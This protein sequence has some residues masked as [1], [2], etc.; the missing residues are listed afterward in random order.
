MEFSKTE[1][2]TSEGYFTYLKEFKG[3]HSLNAVVGYSYFEKNGENFNAENYDFGVEGLKYWDLESGSYLTD[4][5]A[6]MGS[7]KILR[8]VCSL[9]MPVP[10]IHIMINIW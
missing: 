3:G 7:K 5:K 9:F 10:I 1:H 4:G 6:K 2:L 8:N